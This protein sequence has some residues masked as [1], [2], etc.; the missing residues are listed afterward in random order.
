ML[1]GLSNL[2]GISVRADPLTSVNSLKLLELKV[3]C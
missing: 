3:T 1:D 2:P